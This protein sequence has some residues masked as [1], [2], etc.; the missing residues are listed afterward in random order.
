MVIFRVHKLIYQRVTARGL[1][2]IEKAAMTFQPS[3][4]QKSAARTRS[5]PM[6][7][8]RW[9]LDHRKLGLLLPSDKLSRNYGKIHHFAWENSWKFTISMVIFHSYVLVYQMVLPLCA[10]SSG[11]WP[12]KMLQMAGFSSASHYGAHSR[13]PTPKGSHTIPITIRSKKPAVQ[14][15][16]TCHLQ[17]LVEEPLYFHSLILRV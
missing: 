8:S 6:S 11:W 3:I 1:A 12:C 17:E 14:D 4:R 2:C 15:L 9:V 13:T 7:L 16:D 5:S 10:A